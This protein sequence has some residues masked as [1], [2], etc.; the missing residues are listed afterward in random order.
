M[1]LYCFRSRSRANGATQ[2][3]RRPSLAT[4]LSHNRES[5]PSVTT[6]SGTAGTYIPPHMNSN[7]AGPYRNG[8][9]GDMRY[10]REQLINIYKDQRDTGN[11]KQNLTEL[12]SGGWHPTEAR[13]GTAASWGKRDDGKDQPIGP[14]VCWDHN[15]KVQ[16]LGMSEMTDEEREVSRTRIPWWLGCANRSRYLLPPSILL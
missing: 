11:L 12:F 15:G 3:F 7:Y 6:P 8:M 1:T 14:D 4:T 16:P 2:T 13:N 5:A 9:T 10:S